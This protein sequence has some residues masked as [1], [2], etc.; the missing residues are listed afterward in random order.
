MP[1]QPAQKYDFEV[2]VYRP[3]S[4]GGS[5]SLLVRLTRNCPWNRCEFCAMY[6]T[7]KFELRSPAEVKG[8][9]DQV[10]DVSNVC[11]DEWCR[12]AEDMLDYLHKNLYSISEPRW[13][14]KEV[15][16]K[17]HELRDRVKDLYV[18][19]KGARA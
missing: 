17:I 18:H 15:S 11:T 9:I 14:D 5:A 19:F 1:A 4:E 8:D 2:G 3:P 12:S 16:H 10:A 13:A 6:K 7:E